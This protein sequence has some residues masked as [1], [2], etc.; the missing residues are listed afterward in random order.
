MSAGKQA[1]ASE[2][3]DV[4]TLRSACT[5]AIAAGAPCVKMRDRAP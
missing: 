3:V 2:K 4:A 5:P 1:K